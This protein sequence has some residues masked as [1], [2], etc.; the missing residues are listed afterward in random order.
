MARNLSASGKERF[1]GHDEIIVSK[2]DLKGRITYANQVFLEIAGYT[3]QECLGQP[4]SMIRHPNMPRCVF[5]LL[6]ETI[7]EGR[8][9]FAYVINRCK[10][11]DFYWV[12]AHV[13]PSKDATGAI[14]GYHSNRRVPDRKIIDEEIIPLYAQLSEAEQKCANRKEGLAAST[15]LLNTILRDKGLAYDEF[16]MTLGRHNRRGNR[17]APAVPR[18]QQASAA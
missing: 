16:V 18:A 7:Q 9:I 12:Y 5:K 1:F 3:E 17:N 13:T 6:W 4:H 8:E 2:T 14:V 11:G 15:E 10:N